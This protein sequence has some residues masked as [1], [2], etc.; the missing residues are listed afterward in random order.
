MT[1]HWETN[2]GGLRPGARALAA[3]AFV[4]VLLFVAMVLAATELRAGW[5]QLDWLLFTLWGG[6]V[7]YVTGRQTW[8]GRN[9]RGMENL[10]AVTWGRMLGDDRLKK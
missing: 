8:T 10:Y 4:V 1:R 6:L 7:L 2:D 5:G 3:F 9:P